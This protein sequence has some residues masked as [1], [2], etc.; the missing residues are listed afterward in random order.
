MP[1]THV[2]TERNEWKAFLALVPFLSH[3][4]APAFLRDRMRAALERIEATHIHR[5]ALLLEA[6][7][8]FFAD[9]LDVDLALM[10]LVREGLLEPMRDQ[11]FT[12]LIAGKD[13][14]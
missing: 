6:G 13:F 11:P 14:A 3:Q 2:P 10:Q 8:T 5:E 4:A 9:S 12:F 1:K 7:L